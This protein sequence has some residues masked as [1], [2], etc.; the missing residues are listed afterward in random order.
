MNT[1]RNHVQLIGNLGKDF[2]VKSSSNGV[3][4][5]KAPIATNEYYT[6]SKGEKIQQTQWHNIV[7]WGKLAENMDKLLKKGDELAVQGKLV[8]R[9]YEDTKGETRY[10]SEVIV[11][12]FVKLT[13]EKND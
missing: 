9:S 11:N 4:M 5:A 8:H 1:L 10:I 13:K 7:A 6:D 3:S 12:E 2:E